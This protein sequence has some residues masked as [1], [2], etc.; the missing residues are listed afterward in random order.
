MSARVL[1]LERPESDASAARELVCPIGNAS[2]AAFTIT[3]PSGI[4]QHVAG[5][6]AG[7]YTSVVE[8]NADL[9]PFSRPDRGM[10]RRP[11]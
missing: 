11:R 2:N 1:A 4:V 3:W 5:A 6:A 8:P 9:E 7:G 10:T